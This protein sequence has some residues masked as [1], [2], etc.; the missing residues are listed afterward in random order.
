MNW[1]DY[2]DEQ[3]RYILMLGQTGVRPVDLSRRFKVPTMLISIWQRSCRGSVGSYDE[4]SV[5]R[6][7]REVQELLAEFARAAAQA[8]PT[9]TSL[10]S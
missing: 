3:V 2:N 10:A 5:S 7:E 4:L 8:A 1:P 6:L 9:D